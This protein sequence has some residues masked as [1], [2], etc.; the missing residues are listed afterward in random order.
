MELSHKRLNDI[1]CK[2]ELIPHHFLYTQWIHRY[3]WWWAL[4]FNFKKSI[5][6]KSGGGLI[7]ADNL[8]RPLQFFGELHKL[9]AH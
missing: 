4:P 9:C 8:C 3:W 5:F 7:R 1:S 2:S 6:S